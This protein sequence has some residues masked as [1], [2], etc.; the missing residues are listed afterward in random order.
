MQCYIWFM[1]YGILHRYYI[2]SLYGLQ[3]HLTKQ[4]RRTV[5]ALVHSLYKFY[6][7]YVAKHPICMSIYDKFNY[8][9]ETKSGDYY[10]DL[11]M[12]WVLKCVSKCI[13]RCQCKLSQVSFHIQETY[14]LDRTK[15]LRQTRRAD[16]V[17]L[18]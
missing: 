4:S 18:H 15:N 6:I 11:E 13:L 3:Y 7:G 14:Y 8:I 5:I 1:I 10:L 17:F 9:H 2:G 16:S 12:N